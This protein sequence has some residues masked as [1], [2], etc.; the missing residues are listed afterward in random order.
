NDTA[1]HFV[2]GQGDYRNGDFG[3][4]LRSGP[5]CGDGQYFADA[6]ISLILDHCLDVAVA[7][8]SVDPDLFLNVLE[9]DFPGL[10]DGETGYALKLLT[11]LFAHIAQLGLQGFKLALFGLKGALALFRGVELAVEVLLFLL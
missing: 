4:I 7:P 5:G 9:E 10:L 3:Y 8:V 1:L 6:L 11:L 2:V